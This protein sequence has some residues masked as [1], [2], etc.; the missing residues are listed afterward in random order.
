MEQIIC[1]IKQEPELLISDSEDSDNFLQTT[2]DEV[3]NIFKCLTCGKEFSFENQLKYH[4]KV[5]A[6][7]EKM[8]WK[9]WKEVLKEFLVTETDNIKKKHKCEIC[10]KKF[11]KLEY[12]TDH[13]AAHFGTKLTFACSYCGKNFSAK[14]S[15]M[16]HE[17]KHQSQG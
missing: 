3:I 6:K 15:K 13:I 17:R 9:N 5:H 1:E 12:A 16:V 14:G 11:K 4:K 10:E 2:E 8:A 7:K